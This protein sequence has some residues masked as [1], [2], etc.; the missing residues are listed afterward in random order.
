LLKSLAA[1]FVLLILAGV[2]ALVFLNLNPPDLW[3]SLAGPAVLAYVAL[4][5]PFGG[6]ILQKYR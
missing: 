2:M 5:L 6:H 1:A 4:M 3:V